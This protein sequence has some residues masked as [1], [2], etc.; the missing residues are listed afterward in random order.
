M[1]SERR[2]TTIVGISTA[3]CGSILVAFPDQVGQAARGRGVPPASWVVRLL[4]GRYL[5][6]GSAQLR[7]PRPS[8]QRASC[9]LDTLHATSMVAVAVRRPT[10][11]SA[12]VASLGLALI[13]A[14]SSAAVVVRSSG[15]EG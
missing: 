14:F 8:V 10:Y 3:L 2:A 12:A 11:R 1:K 6:Q 4:G 15:G 9:V 13:S 7:W 5:A